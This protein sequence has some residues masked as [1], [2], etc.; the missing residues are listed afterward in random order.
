MC[1]CGYLY[2]IEFVKSNISQRV[3]SQLNDI[4]KYLEVLFTNVELSRPE[5]PHD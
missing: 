3:E 1:V 5:R 4:R 2:Y